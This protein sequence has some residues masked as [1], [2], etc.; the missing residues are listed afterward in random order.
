MLSTNINV[1][2]KMSILMMTEWKSLAMG[3]GHKRSNDA[4]KQRLTKNIFLYL[5]TVRDYLFLKHK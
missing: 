2:V 3:N 5:E 4:E 1:A